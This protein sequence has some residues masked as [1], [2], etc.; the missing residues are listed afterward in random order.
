MTNQRYEPQGRTLNPKEM[1]QSPEV[2]N[3]MGKKNKLIGEILVEKNIITQEQLQNALDRQTETGEKLGDI[4][5]ALEFVSRDKLEDILSDDLMSLSEISI[6]ANVLELV[7]Y[8][9]AKKNILIPIKFEENL[10]TIA[11]ADPYNFNITDDL[12]FMLNKELNIISCRHE[13]ILNAIAQCYQKKQTRKK[14]ENR[15]NNFKKEFD[16]I[17]KDIFNN[18][19]SETPIIKFVSYLITEAY[20]RRASDIHLE[21]LETSFRIRFRIDGVL[22]EVVKPSQRIQGSVISRIKLMAG[23]DIAEKRLP[24]DGRIRFKAGKDWK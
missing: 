15:K 12:K 16:T 19:N 13:E 4:L 22:H 24:Q 20:K 9:Y 8:E 1:G 6:P 11:M 10:V 5:V 23:M 21:P 14:A 2:L 18:S 17:A 7:S 3:L